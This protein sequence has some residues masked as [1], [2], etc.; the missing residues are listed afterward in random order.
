MPEKVI[1]CRLCG[2]NCDSIEK[3][4]AHLGDRHEVLPTEYTVAGPPTQK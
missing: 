4:K 2:E 1:V 3:L